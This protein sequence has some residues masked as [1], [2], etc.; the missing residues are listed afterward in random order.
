MIPGQIIRRDEPVELNAGLPVTT[1]AIT[2]TGLVPVHITAHYHVFEA[3]PHLAFDRLATWGMRLDVPSDGAVRIEPRS[4]VTVTL[5]PIGGA[6]V[7]HGFNDAVNGPLDETDPNEALAKL[8]E[9]GFRH[10]PAG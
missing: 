2:N 3:N 1:V 10:V 6:R 5:V 4:T 8:I 7:V 9:R